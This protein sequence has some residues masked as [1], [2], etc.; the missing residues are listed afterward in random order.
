MKL[1]GISPP[2]DRLM[3]DG[4]AIADLPSSTVERD[5]DGVPIA[6]E[7]LKTGSNPTVRRGVPGEI[8]LDPGD[9]ERMV[10]YYKTKNELIPIES[11]HYLFMLASKMGIDE[12]EVVK[13][14]PKQVAAMGYGSIEQRKDSLWIKVEKWNPIARELLKEG[15]FKYF[16]PGIRGMVNPPLRLTSVA[17]ENE[18][19]LNNLD[20][21]AAGAEDREEPERKRKTMIPELAQ[22]LAKLLKRDAVALSAEGCDE[23]ALAA[24]VDAKSMLL[25]SIRTELKL[26][27]TVSDAEIAAALKGAIEKAGGY[28]AV[29]TQLDTIKA[30]QET[31]KRDALV[32]KG[33][34]DGKLTADSAQ[35]WASKQDSAALAAYLEHAPVVV[36]VKALDPNKLPAKDADA[37]SLSADD[38][39]V[40]QSLGLDREA[41]IAQKKAQKGA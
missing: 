27:D 8:R 20:A 12:A 32:E 34:A 24:E 23:K 5:A 10:E 1:S 40:I 3:G 16:S 6:W 17:L 25:S 15:I 9:I 11:N 19:S 35:N 31:A 21:L 28:D 39:E 37:V 30:E 13:L 7:V 18:P 26:A 2:G 33:L 29:K 41:F 14:L 38:E 4:I 36:P 22:A